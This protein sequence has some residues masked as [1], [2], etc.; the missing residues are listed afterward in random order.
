MRVFISK[1][2]AVIKS[3][4]FLFE[5][6]S[7]TSAFTHCSNSGKLKFLAQ[8]AIG[9]DLDSWI[10]ATIQDAVDGQIVLGAGIL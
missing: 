6:M 3:H 9:V 10:E 1:Q 8:T 7:D 2:Y 4:I 5:C